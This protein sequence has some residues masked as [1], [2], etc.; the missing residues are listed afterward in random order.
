MNKEINI[1]LMKKDDISD[2]ANIEKQCFSVPWSEKSFEESLQQ[3]YAVFFVAELQGEI[4][5]YVGMYNM[6][7]QCD[8]TNVA[9]AGVH[10]RKGIGRKLL[11]AVEHYAVANQ[12]SAIALEVRESNE[13][14]VGLYELM[15][16]KN[17]GI[18]KN[19]YEKPNENAIIMIREL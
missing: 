19:F 6:A 12:V 10:R 8:I 14:A 2:V 4:V 17:V 9:V 1:R 3:S 16:Y 5:G 15:Q 7:G 11:E 18:R 13:A